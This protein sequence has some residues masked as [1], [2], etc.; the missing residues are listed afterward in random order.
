VGRRFFE[1][2][3]R[4]TWDDH[5]EAR[6]T[7]AAGNDPRE[8]GGVDITPSYRNSSDARS[9]KHVGAPDPSSVG[10]DVLHDNLGA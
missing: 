6:A 3:G 2:A 5:Q 1:R 7:H 4:S 8:R 10:Q 9:S